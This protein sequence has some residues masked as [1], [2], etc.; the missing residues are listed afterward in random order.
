MRQ[1]IL[2]ALLEEVFSPLEIDNE[3]EQYEIT[4]DDEYYVKQHYF[5][6][7]KLNE[8]L[9]RRRDAI[10]IAC[11]TLADIDKSF[12]QYTE[13]ISHIS[14][15]IDSLSNTDLDNVGE[16]I[17]SLKN[18]KLN[19]KE[20]V[21]PL[22]QKRTDC[23][24]H[25]EVL[26]RLDQKQLHTCGICLKNP[27]DTAMVPCG[28]TICEECLLKTQNITECFVCRQHVTSMMKLYFL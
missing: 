15:A 20:R 24:K 16:M 13:K 18:L 17:E 28:H 3:D 12:H 22:K 21:D 1:P 27:I 9:K 5:N 25:I 19:L 14:H 11:I 26:K 7:D 10:H 6:P 23:K 4:H 8:E 2:M